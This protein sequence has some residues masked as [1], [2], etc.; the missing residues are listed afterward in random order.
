[1][2]KQE[3]YKPKIHTH[4]KATTTAKQIKNN[5]PKKGGNTKQDKT[6]KQTKI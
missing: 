1:M 5:R 6:N 2:E 3:K 4:I